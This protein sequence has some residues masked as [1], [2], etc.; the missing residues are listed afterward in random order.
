MNRY[1]TKRLIFYIT[2]F[3]SLVTL[4]LKGN[5]GYMP[6]GI[7]VS[8]LIL[9]FSVII[10]LVSFILQYKKVAKTCINLFIVSLISLITVFIISS[11]GLNLTKKRANVI[12]ERLIDYKRIENHYPESLNELI[13]KYFKSIPEPSIGYSESFI[14]E[15]DDCE[16]DSSKG[17]IC[18]E[19]QLLY[20]GQ[21]E[22]EAK[23]TSSTNKWEYDD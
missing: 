5:I 6:L 22:T 21:L 18:K 23:Y 11:I 20:T 17:F 9:F 4:S 1:F 10:W 8:L 19:F 13:P 15:L 7:T 14:Y 2:F 3:L 16:T 12:I